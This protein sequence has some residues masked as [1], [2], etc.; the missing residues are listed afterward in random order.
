MARLM[1][2]ARWLAAAML[3]VVALLLWQLLRAPAPLRLVRF[4]GQTMGTTYHVSLRVPPAETVEGL[5]TA[6]DGRL[7]AVNRSTSTWDPQSELSRLNAAPAGRPIPLS[8]E[9][10]KVLAAAQ[11][12]SRAT[13]GALDVTV[14]P[15]VNLWGFGPDGARRTPGAREI[16]TARAR[17][18]HERLRLEPGRLTKTVEGMYV[19]LSAIAKGY[20]VDEVGRLLR[21]R[22]IDNYL[23]EIGG[24]VLA[25]GERDTGTPWHVG[26][27]RPEPGL[28]QGAALVGAVPLRRGALASSGS[29]RRYRDELGG[30]RHHIID[31]RTGAPTVSPLVAVT[32]WAPDCM[33][34]DALAT[35]L[36]VLGPEQ[37]LAWVERTADVEALFLV[38]L[39]AG[40]FAQ[41]A[42]SGFVTE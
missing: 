2:R 10:Y 20:G 14:G 41:R 26:I 34:A 27:E 31:P 15:L 24:E 9:L 32:V 21:G 30:R 42:S 33:T 29:Y 11:H 28:A 18:G 5:R 3:L 6:V 23:V 38:D 7:A 25:A 4:S 36:M 13:G 35:A 1:A 39:G 12:W 22:G 16:A 19:D 40:G 17:S 37:G 8:D